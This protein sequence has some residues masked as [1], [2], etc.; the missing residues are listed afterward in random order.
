MSAQ[1][2]ESAQA[3]SDHQA[4]REL[5]QALRVQSMTPAARWLWL[6]EAWGPL[7]DSA[8]FLLPNDPSMPGAARSYATLDEKNH[9]DEDREIRQAM[10]MPIHMGH[11]P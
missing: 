1:S 9:F 4:E 8:A 10:H 2:F 5:Q 11:Q 7:Q 6:Q 3:M